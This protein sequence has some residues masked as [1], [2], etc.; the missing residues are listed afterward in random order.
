VLSTPLT[1]NTRNGMNVTVS[2]GGTPPTFKRLDEA[3]PAHTKLFF[4]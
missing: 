1:M 4:L 2:T 3:G